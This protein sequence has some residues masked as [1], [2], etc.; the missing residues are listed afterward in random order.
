MK[1]LIITAHP[2]SK[3][4]THKIANRYKKGAESAGAEVKIM[5]LYKC[6]TCHDFLKFEE[7]SEMMKDD[8]F[9]EANQETMDWADEIVFVHPLWWGGPPAI[10]K[11]FIDQN[12]TPG[13]AYKY[14]KRRF[15]PSWLNLLPEGLMSDKQARVF[16]TCDAP[17][18]L[19]FIIG[20]P[21]VVNWVFF[22]FVFCG[23]KVRLGKVFDRMRFS[24]EAKQERRLAKVENMGR[25]SAKRFN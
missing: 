18:W 15:I 10:L 25:K 4:F 22:V 14:K 19:Y 21:F 13:F 9:R 16:I 17:K 1:I 20:M 8:K 6:E 23:F 12:I 3:G 11:N 5:D 7:V 24:D 2:S